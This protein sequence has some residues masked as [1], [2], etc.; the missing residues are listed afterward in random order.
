[1][2]NLGCELLGNV[3]REE[4]NCGD[5]PRKKLPDAESEA[6][7]KHRSISKVISI[8]TAFKNSRET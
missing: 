2:Q 7:E 1:V 5:N 6:F 8:K 4:S 3:S